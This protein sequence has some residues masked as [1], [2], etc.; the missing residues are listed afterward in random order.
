M[1]PP[2]GVEVVMVG[3]DAPQAPKFRRQSDRSFARVPEK[4]R[5][6]KGFLYL[7]KDLK[8]LT[9]TLRFKDSY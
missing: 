5:R 4:A 2:L 8:I 1:D 7:F 9:K 6:T 3:P